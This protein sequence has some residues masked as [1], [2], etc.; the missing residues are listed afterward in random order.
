LEVNDALGGGLFVSAPPLP[1]LGIGLFLL[2]HELLDG[3]LERQGAGLPGDVGLGS[4]MSW[5]P[6]L[7]A[8]SCQAFAL[9]VAYAR[10]LGINIDDIAH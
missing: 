5:R 8:S 9:R 4:L 1:P 7:S 3:F 2:G 10:L 6:A